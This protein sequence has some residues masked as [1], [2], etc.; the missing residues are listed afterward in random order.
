MTTNDGVPPSPTS[1]LRHR[2]RRPT[3]VGAGACLVAAARV[4]PI[5]LSAL[6]K[7]GEAPAVAH[8]GNYGVSGRRLKRNRCGSDEAE[9]HSVGGGRRPG[10]E[11]QL[12]KNA[13]DMRLDGA[14][15]DEERFRN[16]AVRLTGHE[17]A[18]D[19]ALA[20]SQRS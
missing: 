18:Q 12:V 13:G 4:R 20:A 9:P 16:R 15:A 17:Q 5:A 7:N 6:M 14:P 2:A 10:F 1:F 8:P 11:P 3:P 19:I